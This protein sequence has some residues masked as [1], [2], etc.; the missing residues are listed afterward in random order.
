VPARRGW[1]VVSAKL[2]GTHLIPEEPHLEQALLDV[3][4]RRPSFDVI[5]VDCPIGLVAD[6]STGGRR[7]DDEARSL[8]APGGADVIVDPPT[9]ADLDAAHSDAASAT[10]DGTDA[11]VRNRLGRIREMAE[12]MAPYRQRFVYE[13]R[14]ELTYFR[15]NGDQPL[16]HPKRT[17]RGRAERRAL[18]ATRVE[19]V[20]RVLD[21]VIP[22]VRPWHLL[23]GAA[24]LWTARRIHARAA[25]RLPQDPQWDDEGLRME[26]VY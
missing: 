26:I 23:D 17:E 9:R 12:E 22:G 4:D 19:G 6:L 5:G 10:G 1:L 2:Q 14:A 13:V 18:L 20:Q 3:L 21:S 16:T 24:A 7:C 8:L 25:T 11:L 15:L